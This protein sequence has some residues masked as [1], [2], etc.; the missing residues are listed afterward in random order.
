MASVQLLDDYYRQPEL[1]KEIDR[2]ERTLQR[3]RRERRGPVVTLIGNKPYYHVTDVKDWLKAQRQV[4]E[5]RKR[6]RK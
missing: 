6:R 1:A 3:W 4:P 2:S 5:Q